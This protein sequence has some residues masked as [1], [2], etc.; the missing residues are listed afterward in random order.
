[1]TRGK[2]R[3]HAGSERLA[4]FLGATSLPCAGINYGITLTLHASSVVGAVLVIGGVRANRKRHIVYLCFSM[5]DSILA[6]EKALALIIPSFWYW[7]R[8][9]ETKKTFVI[10]DR[11]HNKPCK[12]KL[13]S[14]NVANLFES[15][16]YL[17]CSFLMFL[18]AGGRPAK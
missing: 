18:D 16:P 5:N 15:M 7:V 12:S 13:R 14:S 10:C 17:P 3:R 4:D 6:Q 2:S 8:L 9:A 1:L 11:I